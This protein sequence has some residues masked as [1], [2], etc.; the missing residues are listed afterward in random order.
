MPDPRQSRLALLTATT[1]VVTGCAGL[2]DQ[3]RMVAVDLGRPELQEF[4]VVRGLTSI[5]RDAKLETN[6]SPREITPPLFWSGIALG[7]LGALGTIGFAAAGRVAKDNLNGMYSDGSGT[8][9]DRNQI[10]NNG[11]IW[12]AL[13]VTSGVLMAIGYA[14]A[15]V[16][17]G[18]DWNR[19]GPLS[20]RPR[21]AEKRLC[22]QGL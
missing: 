5:E 3:P 9:D 10:R 15:V 4:E 14:V 2:I 17:Y 19:C 22:R 8:I 20:R 6:D 12:N 7:S 11:E 16:T 18:V 1:L 21:T 13:A